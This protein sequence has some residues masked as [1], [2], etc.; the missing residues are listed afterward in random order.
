MNS[1]IDLFVIDAKNIV[2]ISPEYIDDTTAINML[3]VT[4]KEEKLKR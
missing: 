3:D 2:R 1:E 4:K